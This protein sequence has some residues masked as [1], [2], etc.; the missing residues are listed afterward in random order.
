MIARIFII[1]VVLAATV[2]AIFAQLDQQARL[3]P[4]YAA[5]VPA[6]LS[7]NAARERSKIALL[8]GDG[9]RAQE[10]AVAQIALRPMPAESLSVL[11]LGAL[12][13]GDSDTART[14]LRAASQRGWRDPVSQLASGQSALEQGEYTIV[15]QRINA[16]LATGELREPAILLLADLI[17]SSEGR[18]AFAD[19]LASS[20]RWQS[21]VLGRAY[22]AVTPAYW[23]RTIALA[24]SKG[25]AFDCARLESLSDRYRRDGHDE[26]LALFQSANCAD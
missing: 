12:Q 9:A 5:L 26:E 20:G 22:D 3:S 25:A 2:A 6:S 4:T 21:D 8:L 15:A 1:L 14:A 23:A 24:Q 17:K 11:A 7:G 10:E 13:A 19:R 16:L 18:E